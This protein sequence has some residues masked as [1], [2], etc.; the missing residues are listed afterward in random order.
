[1]TP[2]YERNGIAIYHCD[3]REFRPA[4]ADMTLIPP[5]LP[6]S[7][8]VCTHRWR[9]SLT[10][11]VWVCLDCGYEVSEMELHQPAEGDGRDDEAAPS[12][13]EQ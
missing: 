11:A 2:Y 7:N 1:M 4:K 13:G 6:V 12:H 3:C 5:R 9:A 10:R 8:P